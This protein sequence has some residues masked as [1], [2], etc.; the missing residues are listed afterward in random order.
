M[1]SDFRE[2]VTSDIRLVL[3]R[4][5]AEDSAYTL[6]ESILQTVLEQF[7]HGISRDRVRTELTWLQEQGVVTLREV[8]GI[9]VATLTQLGADVAAGRH[10]IPGIKRP[11]P[12]R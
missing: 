10:T 6:N 1:A 2:L 9:F 4:T 8:C 5:L 11:S 7:G 12:R 3:V